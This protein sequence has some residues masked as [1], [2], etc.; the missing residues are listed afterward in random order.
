MRM[1]ETTGVSARIA[2]S[3]IAPAFSIAMFCDGSRVART[4]SRTAFLW[5]AATSAT[6]RIRT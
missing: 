4:S 6:S 5:R 2:A 3:S 1:V